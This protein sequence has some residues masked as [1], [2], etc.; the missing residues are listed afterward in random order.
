MIAAIM[1]VGNLIA[2]IFPASDQRSRFEGSSGR[3]H[4][5]QGRG[6][7]SDDYYSQYDSQYDAPAYG[8]SG[9][10][11]RS[12]FQGK[13]DNGQQHSSNPLTKAAD[14]IKETASDVGQEIKERV[15]D[16]SQEIKE[17]V[18]DVKERVGDTVGDMRQQAGQMGQQGQRSM[19]RSGNQMGNQLDEWQNRARYESQRRGQQL[20]RNLEDNPLTYGAVALAAGAALALLLPQTRTE[21]R[22]FGE[23]RD[24]VMDRGQEVVETAKSHAQEVVSEI[25]PELGRKRR[26]RSSAMSKK[27]ARKS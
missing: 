9:Y 21:N 5:A 27:R 8:A 4:V 26:A 12:E 16:A 6:Q 3:S 18:G 19:Y 10:A 2:V 25:R 7:I 22:Y 1:S 13:Q 14:A 24:Q 20:M 15:G 11:T 23:A 17:R